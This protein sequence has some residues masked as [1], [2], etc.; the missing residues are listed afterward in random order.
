MNLKI[1]I[2]NE[3]KVGD[4]AEVIEVLN[5]FAPTLYDIGSWGVVVSAFRDQSL[6]AFLGMYTD[7]PDG[8]HVSK[9]GYRK[10]GKLT[11]TKLK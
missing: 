5:S 9:D 11:I 2:M 7:S 10:V 6:S 8:W 3:L 4:T 1:R